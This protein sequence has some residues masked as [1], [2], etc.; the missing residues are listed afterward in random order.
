MA[1]AIR[2]E[3]RKDPRRSGTDKRRLPEWIQRIG[4]RGRQ[5]LRREGASA[6]RSPEALPALPSYG[7]PQELGAFGRVRAVPGQQAAVVELRPG[8]YIVTFVPTGA[9][10]MGFAPLL[11]PAIVKTVR[12]LFR[13]E[14][15]PGAG[16]GNSA[17][18]APREQLQKQH[19]PGKHGAY[20]GRPQARR[21]EMDGEIGIAIPLRLL[22]RQQAQGA[23]QAAGQAM[24]RW[25][26][27]APQRAG[28]GQPG[29]GRG[30]PGQ[31]P[32]L[33]S[34]VE[35]PEHVTIPWMDGETAE[36]LG[37]G[38]EHGPCRCGRAA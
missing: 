23:G 2:E 36:D 4:K 9:T 27:P 37:L 34:R 29:Q 11:A 16:E 25:S 21:A 5:A 18:P 26:A 6:G 31:R 20:A 7:P 33:L 35:L 38:C 8:M 3:I 19:V 10:E 17:D 30:Q 24:N 22:Q 32:G 14:E 1:K 12:K 15:A 28:R 13:T